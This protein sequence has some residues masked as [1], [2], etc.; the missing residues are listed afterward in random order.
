MWLSGIL[1]RGARL[2]ACLLWWRQRCRALPHH[3]RPQS[4]LIGCSIFLP[5][6]VSAM[7]HLCAFCS[8]RTLTISSS[9][10][11]CAFM[12]LPLVAATGCSGAGRRHLFAAQGC[13]AARVRPA[14]APAARACRQRGWQRWVRVATKGRWNG[15][16]LFSAPF[17]LSPATH[18]LHGGSR[19]GTLPAWR[20][21]LGMLLWRLR[22]RHYTLH[23]THTA[24]L[25][26]CCLLPFGMLGACTGLLAWPLPSHHAIH[27]ATHEEP[28]V[29][30]T[31]SL[32]A[33]SAVAFL[34]L[35]KKGRAGWEGCGCCGG[36][37]TWAWHAG[38]AA[39]VGGKAA[40]LPPTSLP[41]TIFPTCYYFLLLPLY[42]R[43]IV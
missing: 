25:L 31:S 17:Y 10:F 21:A 24:H 15:A 43:N 29:R 41:S 12:H 19:R 40:L 9:A 1:A 18:A 23:Y 3:A 39:L 4:G 20:V 34:A 7:Q 28:T 30:L 5:C 16:F 6:L 32:Y 13:A 38:M 2:A 22:A 8:I 27:A 35:A 36:G 37:W 42:T 26:C 33:I 14:G 11:F